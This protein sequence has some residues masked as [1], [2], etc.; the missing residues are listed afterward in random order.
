MPIHLGQ[1]LPRIDINGQSHGFQRLPNVV[2]NLSVRGANPVNV[3]MHP[4]GHAGEVPNDVQ[5]FSQP[6]ANPVNVAM[7]PFGHAGEVLNDVHRHFT[8]IISLII[9]V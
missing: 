4:F 7:Q 5:G 8:C 6:V 2:H 3:V 9:G 1:T